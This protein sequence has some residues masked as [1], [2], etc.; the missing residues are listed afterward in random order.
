MASGLSD[1]SCSKPQST[2]FSC[3]GSDPSK[4]QARLATLQCKCK[5]SCSSKVALG[6]LQDLCSAYWQMSAEHRA[7]MLYTLHGQVPQAQKGRIQWALGGTRVCFKAFS[8][9]LKTSRRAIRN[10]TTGI[11][12]CRKAMVAGERVP[13]RRPAEKSL[14]IHAFLCELYVTTAEPMPNDAACADLQ[15]QVQRAGGVD[16]AIAAETDPWAEAEASSRPV[17]QL[18]EEG[19]CPDTMDLDVSQLIHLATS[20]QSKIAGLPAKKLPWGK[21]S[22]L[23]FQ[24]QAWWDQRA[25]IDAATHA[26]GPPSRRSFY[27]A[28]A[29]WEGVLKFRKISEH[30]Q[31]ITC[32]ELQQVIRGRKFNKGDKVQAC[33]EL[34]THI[35]E[36]Y[37]DRTIYWALRFRSRQRDG[38]VLTVIIDS[39]DKAK[40]AWPKWPFGRQP[41]SIEKFNRPRCTLTAAIAHGYCTTLFM[42]S[43]DLNHGADHFC[44]VLCQVLE[45]VAQKRAQLGISMPHHLVILSD[46]TDRKRKKRKRTCSWHPWWRSASLS[47]Q[48][49]FFS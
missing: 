25:E 14:L 5:P 17:D 45:Q 2:I 30:A 32:F 20:S 21:V 47:Q 22:A 40:F 48:T 35:M 16:K 28:W 39:M 3:E 7:H 12:D 38:S 27:A 26:G 37:L 4:V 24:F 15:T 36:Q 10:A 29:K 23:H 41:K 8:W 19:V 6:T 31:C 18:G 46:N 13:V 43:E 34:R 44:D 11:P 33:R 9:L 1:S 49:C 42:S